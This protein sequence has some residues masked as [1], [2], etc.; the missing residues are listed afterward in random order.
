MDAQSEKLNSGPKYIIL[1][2]C[3]AVVNSK[4]VRKDDIQ[5]RQNIIYADKSLIFKD[6]FQVQ[7]STRE[8][9]IATQIALLLPQGI[10]RIIR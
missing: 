7:N 6:Y 3:L 2:G 8:E 5:S 9:P 1:L 4:L 10:L